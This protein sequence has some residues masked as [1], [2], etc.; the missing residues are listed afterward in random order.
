LPWALK[1]KPRR[2]RPRKAWF[3]GYLLFSVGVFGII[4]HGNVSHHQVAAIAGLATLLGWVP[5]LGDYLQ[6]FAWD[7]P[8]RWRGALLSWWALLVV[9]GFVTFL[10][11]VSETLKF[12][13]ALVAHAHIAMAGFASALCFIILEGLAPRDLRAAIGQAVAF[14]LWQ[15]GSIVYVVALLALGW[16]ENTEPGVLFSATPVTTLLYSVRLGAGAVMTAVSLWWF[17]RA[18]AAQSS[19]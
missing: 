9:T 10:P 8:F 17:Y 5:L 19:S 1:I 12:T 6:G 7:T 4:D 14:G 15:G 2:E 11:G 16:Y 3:A 18:R 13:N